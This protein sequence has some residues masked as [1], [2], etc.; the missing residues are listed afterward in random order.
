MLDSRYDPLEVEN[1]IYELWEKSG[2]FNPDTCVKKKVCA[3]NA[4]PFSM[5]LPPPNVTGTL[6]MGHAAM[7]AVEDIL[8]RYF[9]M[10]GRKTL[11]LPGTDHAAIATQEK[12]EKE[13]YKKEGTSR[14]QLGR[15]KFLE[16]V[17]QFA[18]ESHDTIINQVRRMGASI[19][20]SREAYTLDEKRN[21]AVRTAFKKMYDDGLIYR[22]ERIVNWDPKLQTTVSDDELEW[23]E[24]TVPLY[25]LKYGPFT[26]ATARPETKFGDKYVVVHPKDKRY[27]KFKH[28][29][30]FELEW[31]NGSTVATLIKDSV[32]DM[33]FGTG[34]MTITPWHDATD[35]EIAERHKLEKEPIIDL[36]GKLLPIAGEFTG[37]SIREA[38]AKIAEKLAGKGLLEKVEEKYVHRVAVSSRGGGTIE[39]QILAQW[40][41]D[42]N[43]K[44]VI[45]NSKI[46][47]IKSKS[48]TS[49]KELMRQSVKSGQIKILPKRFLKIYFHWVDNLRDWCI[50]RQIWFGHQIPVYYCKRKNS[51]FEIRNSK[52]KCEEPIVSIKP[53]KK[54]PHCGGDIEQDSD[55]LDTWFS[56]GLWTFSTLGWPKITP[57]LKT[58]HPTSV[59]ET[60]YDIIF[61]WVARMILMSGYLL[62]DVPFSTVYL[63]GLVR[64]ENGRK[65][66][67]SL[68][69]IIDP[70]EMISKYNADATRLS[71]II[72]A[73]PGNDMKLS[74][75]KVRGY[76]NFTTK[77]WNAARFVLMQS[78]PEILK[79]KP[80]LSLKHKKYLAQAKK[81]KAKVAQNIEKFQL[82]SA[83]E[84]AYHYF[85]HVFA[86]KVIE[87]LK[88]ELRDEKN[89]IAKKAGAY[90]TLE[91]ILEESLVMLHPFVPFVTE[92]IWQKLPN[93]KKGEML[94]IGK[95][96]T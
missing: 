31:I 36:R 30:K 69:N 53:L 83:G 54:C 96:T 62:G 82:H 11:W 91:K 92:E 48:E 76:R 84:D 33:E 68:G 46:K 60:G 7:L 79:A 20:W 66:S 34:A 15:E 8:I 27:E 10:R 88:E 64:D 55:T 71:L 16:R 37:V 25:Y 56:S 49:L 28:G 32:M 45:P 67:K 13:I 39:P 4:K 74:E 89:T 87:D 72:G 21:L 63:H 73:A 6:H 17:N 52:L 93:R 18:L 58:F 22:G 3:K 29:E 75:D 41:G 35:F 90:R 57:D 95:W 2:C 12:V 70:L 51:K 24:E 61:F 23:K 1:R 26:I 59:L 38:R 9:R 85:W 42:V 77:I 80:V 43:K 47:G 65:M 44:F 78:T 86:D 14:H 81:N 50:S 40:F 5:V 94:M 19:D